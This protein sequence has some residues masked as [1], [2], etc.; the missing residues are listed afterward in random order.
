MSAEPGD[1]PPGAA[2]PV[3]ATRVIPAAPSS[4]IHYGAH[5]PLLAIPLATQRCGCRDA[6]GAL[7]APMTGSDLDGRDYPNWSAS[8]A[9]LV[10][11]AGQS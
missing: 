5:H 2:Q 6:T 10:T 3:N 7:V 4:T 9:S 1:P 11:Y 8:F